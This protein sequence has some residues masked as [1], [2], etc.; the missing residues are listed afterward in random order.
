MLL[1][2]RIGFARDTLRRSSHGDKLL[3]REV[4]AVDL[5]LLFEIE[6]NIHRINSLRLS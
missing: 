2:T 5:D 6:S 1:D 3:A 4:D